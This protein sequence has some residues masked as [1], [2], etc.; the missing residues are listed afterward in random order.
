M[1]KLIFILLVFSIA[2]LH[3]CAKEKQVVATVLSHAVTA[4]KMGTRT[5]VTIVETSDGYIEEKTGL[6]YYSIPVGNKVTITVV[7]YDKSL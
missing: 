5:Y 6:S 7:R 3:G 4:D 2:L 1:K